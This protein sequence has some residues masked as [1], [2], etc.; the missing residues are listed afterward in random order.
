MQTLAERYP[1]T[2]ELVEDE[3]WIRDA[4]EDGQIILMKDDRIRRKPREQQAILDTGAR[5]FVVTN[6]NLTAADVA[7]LYLENRHRISQRARTSGPY[8]YGV[9]RGR[10]QKLFP[11][12]EA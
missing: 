5:A 3:V 4:T 2:E 10:L 6:A 12:D 9:Y 11:A 8:I 7:A 1:E